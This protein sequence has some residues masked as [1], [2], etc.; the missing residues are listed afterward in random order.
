V[1]SRSP[2]SSRSPQKYRLRSI[3]SRECLHSRSH[4]RRKNSSPHLR[5][6][7]RSPQKY[8]PCP[9]SHSHTRNRS[10]SRTRS[11]NR[12][13]QE[14]ACSRRHHSSS[15]SSHRSSHTLT[16]EARNFVSKWRLRLNIHWQQADGSFVEH[17]LIQFLLK[18]LLKFLCVR[19][20]RLTLLMSMNLGRYS[21][22]SQNSNVCSKCLPDRSYS[23]GS[24]RVG[25]Y[26][27][28]N[29]GSALLLSIQQSKNYIAIRPFLWFRQII[30]AANSTILQ[31]SNR[32]LLEQTISAHSFSIVSNNVCFR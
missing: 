22:L 26:T 5:S 13:P 12:S 7:S 6:R 18:F 17:H 20:C 31:I 1:R 15:T 25:P 3:R 28:R 9:G 4:S 10:S 14:T 27:I 21:C 32:R 2:S 8:R 19:S 16:A 29:R 30:V 23:S 24:H 11:R